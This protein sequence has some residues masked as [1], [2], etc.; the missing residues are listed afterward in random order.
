MK[1][2]ARSLDDTQLIAKE[3]AS[4]I[5]QNQKFLVFYL[6][7]NLGTGKTTLVRKILQNLGWNLPV[8]SPTFSILE[9]YNVG[10]L[11][12]YHADLYRLNNPNDFEMLGFEPN[13]SKRGVLFIEWPQILQGFDNVTEISISIQIQNK[14]R[15]FE[16]ASEDK[17]FL[18]CINRINI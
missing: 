13:F 10:N 12:I 4:F 7:G 14:D 5:I 15:I 9:E 17:E 16:F 8:K 1:L 18:S 2:I 11:E 3:I 6:E